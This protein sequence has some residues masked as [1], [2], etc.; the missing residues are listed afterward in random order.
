[1]PCKGV[2]QDFHRD[3][4]LGQGQHDAP[5]GAEV[6]R[7]VQRGRLEQIVGDRVLDEGTGDD[8]VV[9]VDQHHDQQNPGGVDQLQAV[10]HHVGGHQAAG[11]VHGEHEV[12]HDGVARL[13][14]RA[15]QR[16]G[17]GHGDDHVQRRAE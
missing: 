2:I 16:V 12:H 11:E 10:D 1:M 5:E 3:D 7:A 17:G 6:V 13:E 4:G 15:G 8:Q 9:G 14:I